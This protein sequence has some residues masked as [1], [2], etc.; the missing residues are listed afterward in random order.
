MVVKLNFWMKWTLKYQYLLHIKLWVDK[1]FSKDFPIHIIMIIYVTMK[2]TS[3]TECS[4]HTSPAICTVMLN[5]WLFRGPATIES[6]LFIFSGYMASKQFDLP[7]S[8]IWPHMAFDP[9]I[10]LYFGQ[11]FFLPNLVAIEHSWAIWPQLTLYDLWP[12]HCSLLQSGVL[13]T[14]FAGQR[15]WSGRFENMR[16]NILGPFPT[17]VSS[18]S[19]ITQSTT[20]RIAVHT[21]LHTYIQTWIF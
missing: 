11:G 21:Y 19:W 9:S 7:L 4:F 10:A 20:K 1:F 16:S 12:Q 17:P 8:P 2:I 3:N 14:K 18:F 13:P 6:I 15:A 5:T